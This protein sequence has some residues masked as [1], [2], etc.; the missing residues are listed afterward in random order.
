MW[1]HKDMIMSYTDKEYILCFFFVAH[2]AKTAKN[3]FSE[4]IH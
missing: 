2:Y 3:S 1:I 4:V